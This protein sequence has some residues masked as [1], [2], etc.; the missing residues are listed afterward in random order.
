M[1]KLNRSISSTLSLVQPPSVT[2]PPSVMLGVEVPE[3]KRLASSSCASLKASM[4]F[5]T[6]TFWSKVVYIVEKSYVAIP[7]VCTC[8]ALA[9]R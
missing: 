5:C 2:Q 6:M 8:V 4:T 3:G 1:D 9:R 7:W